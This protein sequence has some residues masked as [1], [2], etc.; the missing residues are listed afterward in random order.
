MCRGWGKAGSNERLHTGSSQF[1]A[2]EKGSPRQ[3]KVTVHVSISRQHMALQHQQSLGCEQAPSAA[4][5]SAILA[6]WAAQAM[7]TP[8]HWC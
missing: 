4:L 6:S 3:G 5:S 1:L 2:N 7:G 8:A